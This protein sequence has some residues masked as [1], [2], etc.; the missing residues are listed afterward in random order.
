VTSLFDSSKFTAELVSGE[1]L[2]VTLYAVVSPDRS[3][4]PG[5][6]AREYLKTMIF[7]KSINLEI[8]SE[9][10]DTKVI[11]FAYMAN[12][13]NI[14]ENLL[15]NGWAFFDF[16]NVSNLKIKFILLHKLTEIKLCKNFYSKRCFL[17]LCNSF[18]L[19]HS[20]RHTKTG[21]NT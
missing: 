21:R 15:T 5:A 19:T 9:E 20:N 1:K 6:A 11:A 16:Y 3:S 13:Q 10:S 12:G 14:N 8:I 2:S 18:I 17:L 4:D 7:K